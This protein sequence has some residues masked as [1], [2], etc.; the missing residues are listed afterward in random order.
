MPLSNPKSISTNSLFW[1]VTVAG[2]ALSVQSIDLSF[3]ESIGGIALAQE[4]TNT[5]SMKVNLKPQANEIVADDRGYEVTSFQFNASN[6]QELCP[7]GNCEY[8]IE[9]GQ[10]RTFTGGSGYVFE[11]RLKVT[12]TEGDTKLS[13]F[14]DMRADLKKIGSEETPSKLTEI[15]EGNIGFVGSSTV[16]EVEYPTVN[17]TLQL[18]GESPILTL[19]GIK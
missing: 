10:Y 11:G 8:D 12:V 17:G 13:K 4:A 1:V 18:D 16:P 7:L 2:L 14:Y 15:L 5:I 9:D 19:Q 3:A 6:A